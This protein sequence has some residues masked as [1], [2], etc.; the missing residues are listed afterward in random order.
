MKVL[1]RIA[2]GFTALM[3]F[4]SC[5]NERN[6][7]SAAVV[8]ITVAAASD[9]RPVFDEIGTLFTEE[10]GVLITFVYGSSGLLREQIING[11]PFDLY[12]SAN[13]TLVDEV[14]NAGRGE[15]E[16][17]QAFA[18]GRLALWTNDSETL[19]V[20]LD[21]LQLSTYRRIVI[22]NPDHAPYGQAARDVLEN[23]DLWDAINDR[24]VLAENIGDAF[25]IVKSGNADVG[26]VALSLVITE[27]SGY[28]VVPEELH[29]PLDQTLVVLS[30]GLQGETAR[31]FSDFVISDRGRQLLTKYGFGIP[32]SFDNI[33]DPK[34][35]G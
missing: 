16:S 12:A 11:A 28:L 13:S 34:S 4:V 24:L 35:T 7:T 33:T 1:G 19:P 6:D 15:R 14:L 9:L 32:G 8:E 17:R 3:S 21:D 5:A 29:R 26:L 2:V 22:A 20:A 18:L 27:G 31:K 25:R 10:T 30:S 23:R